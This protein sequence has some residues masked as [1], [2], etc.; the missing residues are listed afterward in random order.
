MFVVLE[1]IDACGKDTQSPLLIERF[2][3]NG[4][5]AR[6]FSFPSKT[7]ILGEAI[8]RHLRGET[9]LD[10]I[11][12]TPQ[13]AHEPSPPS[14]DRHVDDPLVFQCMMIAD[15]CEHLSEITKTLCAGHPVIAKRWWPSG[16]VYGGNEGLPHD[17]LR[18]VHEHLP[19]PD[20]YILLDIDIETTLARRPERRDNYEKNL[21]FLQKNVDSY[22]ELW[23]S[24]N[25]SIWHIVDG[26]LSPEEVH[27]LIWRIIYKA[28]D[29]EF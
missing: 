7:G 3:K 21:K 16:Y 24:G 10:Y 14:G 9:F 12:P 23:K 25:P 8:H 20:L 17:W 5:K 18:K 1:G 27:G 19:K 22:R 13:G 28:M 2:G 11:E 6:E 29:N 15:R 4:V 26:R